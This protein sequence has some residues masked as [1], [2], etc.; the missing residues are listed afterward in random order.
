MKLA[1]LKLPVFL[2]ILAV[3]ATGCIK[4]NSIKITGNIPQKASGYVYINRLEINTPILIDSVKINK[5]GFFR[6]KIKA[7][8]PDFYQVA[9]DANNFIT[10]LVHPEE[11][12]NLKFSSHQLFNNYIVEGSEES[13][14]IRYLDQTLIDTQKKLDSLSAVYNKAAL[15][16]EFE[17]KG[18]ELENMFS[19]IIKQQRRK[20]IEFIINNLTSLASIKAVYQRIDPNTYV[21]YDPKD[22]QY[23]K[24]VA[25]SLRKYYPNSKHV[26]ALIRDF[27]NELTIFNTNQISALSEKI[28][29]MKLNP[30]LINTE[31]KRIS[32][33]SLRGKYVL[34]TFWSAF[35]ET[36]VQENIELK[37]FYNRYNR[38]G[39][40]IY[41]INLDADEEFWKTAVRYEELKWVSVREDDAANPV[42]A[43]LFN[44][45]ELPTNYLFDKQGNIIASNLHGRTL[46]IKLEQL[47]GN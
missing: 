34:L 37:Q 18:P 7:S 8:V 45:R 39:F 38:K 28:D 5:N 31:G 17:T 40:E 4:N 9:L 22:L 3:S 36:C 43:Q 6:I 25:D 42:V 24:N 12:I 23:M 32:L 46:S 19:D 16:P 33:E 20:N 14:K 30:S 35:S 27:E 1:T 2:L 41:Q 11:R 21:L 10:L 44:V 29:P 47:F 26:K 13:E 15:E